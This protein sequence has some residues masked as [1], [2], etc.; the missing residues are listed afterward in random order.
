[1][2]AQHHSATAG[3]EGGIVTG[4][5][6]I[7]PA[8]DLILATK[9]LFIPYGSSLVCPRCRKCI[10]TAKRNTVTRTLALSLTGLLLYGPAH[11]MVLLTFD[12]LGRYESG[13]VFD[14]VTALF[15]QRYGFVSLAV[16][17]TA[18]VIPL[19]KL[20]LLFLVSLGIS[21]DRPV[22]PL[23]ALLRWYVHLEEWGMT[24]VYLIGILVTIVKM[25]PTTNIAYEPGFYCFVG[26]VGVMVALSMVFDRHRF[27]ERMETLR[28][29]SSEPETSSGGTETVGA[30]LRPGRVASAAGFQACHTC[31]KTMRLGRG[32]PGERYHCPRCGGLAHGR[33]TDSVSRTMALVVTA[34]VLSFPANL[35]PIME[36]ELFGAPE[37]STIMDGIRYFFRSGTYGIG[38][39]ILCA[40][41]LVPLFKIL[42]LS[43]LLYSIRFHR[44]TRLVQKALMFRF[45]AFIGRWS[46]LDIFVIALLCSLVNFGFLTT[47]R[48][49]PAAVFFTLVVAST[50]FAAISFDERLLWDLAEQGSSRNG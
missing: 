11:F 7:C 37:K 17:L 24:D 32:A 43:V 47:V 49:A 36:V 31:N 39:I 22:S 30:G 16:L 25:K 46:M 21:L 23:R 40:S 44:A 50:M 34:L 41:I 26:L 15:N 27:W 18:Q 35:L 2:E 14:S 9:P 13:S 3:T 42:G 38:L 45:I 48:P 12:M 5:V 20:G 8:C 6:T 10:R 29:R 1:M 4:T 28:S 19:L 33:V